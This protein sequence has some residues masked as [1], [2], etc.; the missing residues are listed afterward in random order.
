MSKALDDLLTKLPLWLGQ[1]TRTLTHP[2]QVLAEQLA[3]ADTPADA[4]VEAKTEA[5]P[6]QDGVSFLILSF[7]VAAG[8][9]IAFPVPSMSAL[10]VAKADGALAQSAAVLRNLFVFLGAAAMVHGGS[11]LVG[12]R[13]AFAGFFGAVARFGGAT[14]VL[15]ALA[16]ALTNVGMVDPIVARNWQELRQL[17]QAFALPMETVLCKV[18]AKTGQ[19]P[20]GTDLGAFNPEILLRGQTLFLETVTRPMFL[21]ATGLESVCLFALSLWLGWVWWRYLRVSG[22]N[23]ARALAASAV[24][25]AGLGAGYLLLTLIAGG[26]MTS[27]LMQKC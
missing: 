13:Q 21:I 9:S 17:T 15:L 27:Q 5:R 10:E 4:K 22:L 23:P 2:S 3:A 11:K 18:D 1:F 20:P 7:A 24:G 8:V 12:N 16:G 14:L 26:Q 6:V 19:L 25:A